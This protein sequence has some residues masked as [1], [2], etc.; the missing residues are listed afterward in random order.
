MIPAL[1]APRFSTRSYTDSA[2][3]GSVML[4]IYCDSSY[5]EDGISYIGIAAL[6]DGI[7]V[8]QSTTAVTPVPSGNLECER[9]AIA[10][11]MKLAR[12]LRRS[13]EPVTI[14]NDSTE[15]VKEF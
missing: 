15:A 12:A 11:A 4:E 10:L 13:G 5:N 1:P 8:H 3:K 14:Y 7:E 9:A 6:A 2:K